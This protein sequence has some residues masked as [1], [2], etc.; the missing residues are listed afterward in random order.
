MQERKVDRNIGYSAVAWLPAGKCV[1]EGFDAGAAVPSDRPRLNGGQ[2]GGR[3][4]GGPCG[5]DPP[6][7]ARMETPSQ[8]LHTQIQNMY[9]LNT[10][11]N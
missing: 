7:K 5:G 6:Q 8:T 10:M 2:S 3:S 4:G 11:M 1:M 9:T